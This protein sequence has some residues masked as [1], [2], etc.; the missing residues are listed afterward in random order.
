MEVTAQKTLL[1]ARLFENE[2]IIAEFVEK[3]ATCK[4]SGTIRRV[5]LTTHRVCYLQT[6]LRYCC[7]TSPPSMRQVF[8][9]DICDIAIDNYRR[10]DESWFI[11]LLRFI[12]KLFPIIGIGL[13]I[14]DKMLI[15]STGG[16]S[17]VGAVLLIVG[18]AEIIYELCRKPSPQI[19]IGTRCPQLEAFAITLANSTDRMQLV[20]ELS[21]LLAKNQ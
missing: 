18:I 20:D 8:I 21:L 17:V 15:Y 1:K 19:I 4:S 6:T 10:V 7:I 16:I 13:L 5:Q 14:Y 9:K 12:V 11:Q 2:K 3:P